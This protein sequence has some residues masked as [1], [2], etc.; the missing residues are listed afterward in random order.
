MGQNQR[1]WLT[2]GE[3]KNTQGG[4]GRNRPF[5]LTLRNGESSC[6]AQ[7]LKQWLRGFAWLGRWWELL[8]PNTKQLGISGDLISSVRFESQTQ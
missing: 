6:S 7:Q 3:R 2:E 4:P 8:R 5:L 1:A